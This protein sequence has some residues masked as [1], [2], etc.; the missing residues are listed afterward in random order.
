MMKYVSRL[1]SILFF[2]MVLFF[3]QTGFADDVGITKARLIQTDDS[4]FVLEVD[5]TMQLVWAI[6]APIFP[7]RFRVSELEFDTQAGW[8]V[9]QVTATTSGDPLSSEDEIL[10]PWFRNGVDITV[11]WLDGSLY[12]GLFLRSLEGIHVPIKLLMPT[13]KTLPELM[14][15]HLFIGLEHFIFKGIHL[16]FVFVLVLFAYS[17]GLFRILLYYLF[18]QAFSLI[19]FEV[20]MPGFDLLF[21][22]I[23]GV[24]LIFMLSYA[25]LKGNPVHQYYFLILLFGTFHGLAYAGELSS[26]ELELDHRLPALFMF[27]IAIDLCNYILTLVLFLIVGV[28]AKNPKTKRIL[29]YGSGVLS[30]AL[31]LI[32]FQENIFAGKT[33]ILKI[34]DEKIATQFS[35]PTSPTQ[36]TGSKQQ[37]G[38]RKLTTPVISYLSVEPYEVRQEI[39]INARTA[40]RFLGVN[41]KGM[42]SIPVESLDPI[43]NG[44]LS[45][46]EEANPMVIDGNEVE[47]ILTRADFVTLGP[48][49]VILRTSPVVESL[50][51]GIIGITL[52]YE[53][54]E[55]ANNITVDWKLFSEDVQKIEATTI[56]PFGGST[57]VLTIDDNLL[58][59]K[60][61]LSGY[62]V[63][64]IGEILVEKQKIPL[65]SIVLF[66]TGLVLLFISRKKRIT[67]VSRPVI[68]SVVG[69]A[70]ILYPFMRIS[71]ELP[72]YL[73]PAPSK[74]RTAIILDDLLTNVYR[75]FDIRNES[76]IYDRLSVSVVGDQLSKI[77][78]ES[79]R[80][81]EL[82]NRGGA[83]ARIDDVEILE[84]NSVESSKEGGLKIEGIWKVSGS[85]NHYGHTHYRQNINNAVLNLL[86]IEDAW[87]IQGIEII[88]EQRIL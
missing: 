46:F 36:Q 71:V 70:F 9:V 60:R 61:R 69:L 12:Q 7:D 44:V 16:L 34:S 1:N 47:P 32:I 20:G 77:Y 67:L 31:I 79:R 64:I 84:V 75:S 23:M 15:E 13:T 33:N 50:D 2:W 82:E 3:T 65:I 57:R 38:A 68:L 53:T 25:A 78:L 22:D 56:D 48:A 59:W 88:D 72:F 76:D 18:G 11:Q 4:T 14:E 87:K 63:P 81:L 28:I 49:G 85:V 43:K 54:D 62:K 26:F 73:T 29:V 40:V 55:L 6:K 58:E 52:V 80:L 41:D 10:L 83:R 37:T 17:R 35:L 45:I 74:E 27:N 30:V 66:L 24:I 51:N 39:L 86:P 5:V 19:L 42:G 8:I 21:V